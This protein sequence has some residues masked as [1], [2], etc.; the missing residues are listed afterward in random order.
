MKKFKN[1]VP[2]TYATASLDREEAA[3]TSYEK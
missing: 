2:W 1:T 3:G